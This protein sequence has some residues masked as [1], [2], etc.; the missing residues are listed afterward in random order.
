MCAHSIFSVNVRE[1]GFGRD[2]GKEG[3]YEYA[4]PSWMP[5]IKLDVKDDPKFGATLPGQPLNPLK[6]PLPSFKPLGS[7]PLPAATPTIDRSYKL[8]IGG[9]QCRPDATY[10]RTVKNADHVARTWVAK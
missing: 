8:F 2:G 1:S 7:L 9:K 3:L 4:K 5:S 6:D 10:V